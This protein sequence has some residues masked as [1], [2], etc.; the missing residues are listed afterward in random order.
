MCPSE[1]CQKNKLVS[2]IKCDSIAYMHYMG[3]SGGRLYL[4]TRG[5]KF[6]KFQELKLQECV[7]VFVS[8]WQQCCSHLYSIRMTR[9]QWEAFHVQWQY[10]VVERWPDRP[11]QGIMWLS[12]EYPYYTV[13]ENFTVNF[14]P[15]TFH[16][17][18]CCCTH[19][20]ETMQDNPLQL[21][22]QKSL[23]SNHLQNIRPLNFAVYVMLVWETV[24][25]LHTLFIKGV[26]T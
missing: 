8:T 10:T 5:S 18:I 6:V 11:A 15:P 26:C 19:S 24:Y 3:R 4:Q 12:L 16:S 17:Q 14:C 2:H 21:E 7:S 13:Y 25:S 20:I 22:L 1:E 23:P 9:Y